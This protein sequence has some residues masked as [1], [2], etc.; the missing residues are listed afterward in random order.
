MNYSGIYQDRFNIT[1]ILSLYKVTNLYIFVEYLVEIWRDLS[2]RT[3]EEGKGISRLT[4]TKYYELNGIISDRLFSI[5]DSNGDNYLDVKEFVSGMTT[6][7]SG[8][9]D[10]LL[11]FIFNIYD[12]DKDGKIKVNDVKLILDYVPIRTNRPKKNQLLKYEKA[13]FLDR[14]QVQNE[15]S[16]I[17]T[18]AFGEK[19]FLELKSFKKVIKERNSDIFL[20]LLLFIF[21]KRPFNNDTLSTIEV[22]NSL[23]DSFHRSASE[24]Y[25]QTF[26]FVALPTLRSRILSPDIKRKMNKRSKSFIPEEKEDGDED[27]VKN[28]NTK[29]YEEEKNKENKE[30]SKISIN[31]ENSNK[32]NEQENNEKNNIKQN[33]YEKSEILE[34]SKQKL[35]KI[36]ALVTSDSDLNSTIIPRRKIGQFFDDPNN[37]NESLIGH[38]K[39]P[40]EDKSFDDNSAADCD[41]IKIIN[42]EGYIYK[43]TKSNKKKKLYF[44]LV[45]RDLFFY[46]D[47]YAKIFIGFH[48]LSDSFVRI[49]PPVK[50]EDK[51]YYSFSLIY[52]NITRNYLLKKKKRLNAWVNH[53]KKAINLSVLSEFF[54]VKGT[55]G[56]GKFG[57][58]KLGIHKLTGRKVA[59][60]IINKN[61]ITEQEMQLTK[62]EIEILKIGQH[63]NIITLYDVIEN[64]EKIYIIMEY[65]S[66]SDLF[67][68][69]EERNFKLPEKHAAEIIRK[70]SSAVYY[71]HSFGIIHRDIKPE[72]IL[73]TDNTDQADIR[74]LDFGLSK[75]ISQGE[76][77][78]EPYGTLSYVSPEVLQD[79]PY[80]QRTDLWSIG[81]VSYLLLSGVLPFDDENNNKEIARKTVYEKTPFYPSLWNDVS[82]EAIDFVDKLLQKDP[83]DRMNMDALF[84]HP[85]MKKYFQ[86][87]VSNKSKSA[88]INGDHFFFT[89]YKEV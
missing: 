52:P 80:D 89:S 42:Y 17:L 73:M 87:K 64:E 55:L 23:N 68:Y 39:E 46:K 74:L 41:D 75:I 32:N 78:T 27:K 9:Y 7:F 53:L 85:W 14:I 12:C 62:T 66:G 8:Y 38:N 24:Q 10:Q 26:H 69:I 11:K 83:N 63:P 25:G 35:P 71:L 70:L 30:D 65:C 48:H 13:E 16:T 29:K 86:N 54:D 77:C 51:Q 2:Q 61:G 28:I 59:I 6:L 58:V 82:K 5:F 88:G 22:Y 34:Q 84:E 1:D 43:I 15:L 45:F 40:I 21:E 81:V 18:N 60:K 79:I 50:F 3:K 56:K 31:K 37:I 47:K 57:L 67:A 44:K 49:N 20:F 36:L 76:K 19:E 4:F 72:N 33:G